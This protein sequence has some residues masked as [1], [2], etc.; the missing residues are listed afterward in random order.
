VEIY[1]NIGSN[2]GDRASNI[3][4]AVALVAE[5]WP[6]ATIR[7]APIIESDPD[8]YES[9]N[10][11][12]N[13]GI[14]VDVP[15]QVDPFAVLRATQAIEKE[16]AP[17]SPHRNPDGSYRDREVDIDI[18]A[19]DDIVIDSPELTLP[20]PRA[21]ARSFVM[22][23][24]QFLR[25]GWVPGMSAANTQ[26]AKKT[27]FDMQR[28]T[29]DQFRAKDKLT[30]T[31]VLDNIRSLNNVGSMFRTADAFALEGLALCG[32]TATPPSPEIH[33]TALGA[34]D[35][36]AWT[37]YDNTVDAIADLHGKGYIVACLEQVKDSISLE[38]FDV[39]PSRRYAI[40]VGN[41]VTGVDN[42]VVAACDAF[43]EIP[44][45]G[46]KHSLNVA[47]SAAIAMWHFFTAMANL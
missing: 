28:D 31:L 34:E 46:T 38:K 12:L 11:F 5:R 2:R 40:V 18:I 9:P 41:E 32:I 36:V 23:P 8:G 33:K 30:L 19:I 7:R 17:D 43:I 27:V 20:H 29:V 21:A 13:L 37:H 1:L 10:R 45:L 14:A 16:L 47:N 26:H 24:M 25:P 4:R 15:T 3:E 42:A 22:T 39:D 35:S 6:A 44:Q